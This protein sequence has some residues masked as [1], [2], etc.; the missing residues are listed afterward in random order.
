MQQL[1][2]KIIAANSYKILNISSSTSV[3][4]EQNTTI[5]PSLKQD[6]FAKNVFSK[7]NGQNIKQFTVLL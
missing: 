7:V 2:H 5:Q 4:V 3:N 1:K 6:A